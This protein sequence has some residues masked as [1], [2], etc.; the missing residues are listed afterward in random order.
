MVLTLTPAIQQIKSWDSEYHN[1]KEFDFSLILACYCESPHLFKNVELLAEYLSATVYKC[2]II[3][4]EDCSPDD[5]FEKIL[6]CERLLKR[7]NISF[8]ILRHPVNLGRG[9]TVQDGFIVARG[10]VVGY[11]DI[12]LEHPMDALLSMLIRIR[13]GECDAVVAHRVSYK[14]FINPLRTWMSEGYKALVHRLLALPVAD[15]EAGLKLFSREKILPVLA[16]IEDKAW[17]WDTEIVHRAHLAGLVFG[18]QTI[19]FKRNVDKKST[20]RVFRDSWVYFK[21]LLKYS[22]NMRQ[23]KN[24]LISQY[25]KVT[26]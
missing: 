5:T 16:Q 24:K 21:T 20:V 17:F 7:H 13:K 18:E 6:H 4:V 3:F 10:N 2:E 19:V 14:K 12:D 23:K 25:V 8:Q 1:Q 15:T 11:I 26:A 9:A 22:K